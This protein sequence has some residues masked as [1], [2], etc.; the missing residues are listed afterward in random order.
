MDNGLS[1]MNQLLYG[2]IF[3]LD[4]SGKLRSDVEID[5]FG[6]LETRMKKQILFRHLC[7]CLGA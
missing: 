1:W 3:Q 5:F 6:R 2:H 7:F 4:K